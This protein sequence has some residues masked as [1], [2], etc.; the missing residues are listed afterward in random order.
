M[1]RLLFLSVIML[2]LFMDLD[3]Q[4]NAQKP[5]AD[6]SNQ[7]NYNSYLSSLRLPE[8]LS[9][10]GEKIPLE[11]PEVKQRAERE[12]YLT[13][14]QPGQIIL[15]LKRAG[16][17]FPNFEQIAKEM[18]M[19]TDLKYL[20]VAESALYMA[21]S[22][23][24]AFGLWQFIEGTGKKMGLIINDYID[25]RCNVD[26]S[27]R[28]AMEYLAHGYQV[29]KSWMLTAAGYN[30]GHTGLADNV[31][32]QTTNDFFQLFVNEETSRYIFRI[33]II[34]E[35]MENPKKYGFIISPNDIYKPDKYKVI[36][37]SEA[38]PNLSNWAIKQGTT[39]KD[40]K[41][42]NPWI[43]KRELPVPIKGNFYEI[44]V[45]DK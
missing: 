31:D 35:I 11:I 7:Y 10:C 27:T 23:K 6:L 40:I 39:Y 20:S 16:R 45:P 19:P 9:F 30:M 24:N 15:Y 33:A 38:I 28:A 2:L 1:K 44:L 32:F 12:F 18:N 21:R 3:C 29:H 22:S 36:K 34:K 13:L 14:Q 8:T 5:V 37:W 4:E 26:K 41:L 42:L 25:E 17:Y 43:L